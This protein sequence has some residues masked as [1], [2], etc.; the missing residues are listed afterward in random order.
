MSS[1][2]AADAEAESPATATKKVKPG[3]DAVAF[4]PTFGAAKPAEAAKEDPKKAVPQADD[5]GADDDDDDDDVV[6]NVLE[7]L[8]K[9]FTEKN[10]RAPT[11]HDIAKWVEE[12]KGANLMGGPA[13]DD[14]EDGEDEDEDEDE[15]EED[16]SE[17]G[18]DA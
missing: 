6:G 10:G 11:E 3:E 8:V 5:E 16:E 1:K 18:D 14:E 9:M 12:I 4:D 15:S 2:R 7:E 13:H 17:D